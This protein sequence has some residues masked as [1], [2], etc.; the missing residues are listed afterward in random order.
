LPPK[1]RGSFGI[2]T[3]HHIAWSVP[4]LKVLEVWPTLLQGKSFGVTDVRVRNYIK[5][6]YTNDR[7]DVVIEF[8]TDEPGFGVDEDKLAL[9]SALQQPP[10][11]EH[12]REEYERTMPKLNL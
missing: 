5:S 10:Q 8:A 12:K 7:G 4:N 9:V 3:V 1:P 2:G 6:I 11:Y